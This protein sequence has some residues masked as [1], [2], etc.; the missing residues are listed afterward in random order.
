MLQSRITATAMMAGAAGL[1][2]GGCQPSEQEL[3]ERHAST[4]ESFCTDCHNDAER[5]GEMTLEDV[6]LAH[7]AADPALWEKVIVKLRGRLMPPPGGPRP[8]AEA[9]DEFVSFLETRLDA[10]AELSPRLARTGIHRLNRTEYGNAVRDLLALEIDPAEFLPAD[11]EGYG[12][13]NIADILRVSPSLLE[14]YLAA[15][16]KIA[17]LAVGDPETPVVT[18]VYRAPPDLAQSG[19]V[20]GLP[21]G[22][23]GGMLIRHNFPLDAEYDFSVFLLRNIVGYMKGLEWPHRFEIT[24]D[25]ERVF[26]AQVGG[27]E[28]NAMSDANFSAAADTIDQRLR[29]RVFVEAG[30]HDVG[31]A[32]LRRNSAETHEPLELHTRDLDLQNMN[33]EPLVDYMNITGPFE[34]TGAGDTPSR[35]RIFSCRPGSE[36]DELRCAEEILSTLARRAYRRPVTEDDVGLL[37]RFFEAG[38][39]RGGF[40]AGIQN[41]LRV[42]LTAP[43]FLF[44]SQPDPEGVAP[45]TIYAVDDLALASRLS[46]F[47]WSS[48][49]DD[50]L[51]RVAE[52]GR[53]SEPAEYERQ[54]RRMLADE[55]S[56]ALVENFAGQWLYLRNLRSAR[57]GVEDFPDFDEN[58]RRAMLRETQLFFDS[59]IREDRS[60]V[61]LLTA[62]YTFV[63]ERLAK[64]YG[65]PGVYGSHF[66]RIAAPSDA[67]RGL[68]GHGSILTVTSYPNRTSPVL[69][70]KWVM[71][72][73]LG[74]PPPAP[75]PNVPALDENEPGGH[76]RSVRERLEEHRENPVCAACHDVMDPLGL[77]LEN[78]DAV[79]RWRT[80]EPGGSIDA[81]GQLADGTVVNGPVELREALTAE[82][83]HFVGVVAEKLMIYALGRGLTPYDM[84]TVRSI[85]RDAAQAD[86]RFSS[87]VLGIVQSEAFRMRQAGGAEPAGVTAAVQ[88]TR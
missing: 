43:S 62:D 63:N 71:E 47:L 49:P 10:A 28:D 78:F 50:E 42:V 39:E 69:R 40:D 23:R 70:G 17:A 51:L 60:V 56:Y 15:S 66:R 41:A 84:P 53:L 30:P 85:V 82:P 55:R 11:D 35:R 81:S 68:L 54:V 36:A 33:G 29:T 80:A 9:V 64:H 34:A 87:L 16:T 32:F 86:Y 65:I 37:L 74:T 12:F 31:V 46:F 21:L 22:T 72:N 58:L 13:D 3:V 79:G 73:V 14:Q 44:R 61:D 25:G 4:I 88:E 26:E 5:V 48:I 57:P 75:P 77:A 20:D 6:D 52:Q 38:S 45:G 27:E 59:I 19:H 24:V 67:R 1:L 2:L 7:V 83:E 8:D 18:S 76:A